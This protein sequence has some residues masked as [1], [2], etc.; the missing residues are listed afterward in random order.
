VPLQITRPDRDLVYVA[1]AIIPRAGELVDELADLAQGSL[2]AYTPNKWKKLLYK[3]VGTKERIPGGW[4]VGGPTGPSG[5]LPDPSPSPRGVIAEFLMNHPEFATRNS[6]KGRHRSFPLAWRHLSQEARETLRD[7]RLGGMYHSMAPAAPY[8]LIAE[9]GLGHTGVPARYYL[10]NSREA[11][12]RAVP[13]LS[14]RM[15]SSL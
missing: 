5:L 1:T 7:E 14:S 9:E 15:W 13:M 6:G 3:A 4:G 10:R 8:W 2:R 11:V 12:S